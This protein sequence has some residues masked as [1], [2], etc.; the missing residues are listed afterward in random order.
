MKDNDSLAQNGKTKLQLVAEMKDGKFN[1]INYR[2]TRDERSPQYYRISTGAPFSVGG[3]NMPINTI[4]ALEVMSTFSPQEWYVINL[5]KNVG[6]VHYDSET[7][8]SYS[9]NIVSLKGID[10]DKRKFSIG[11]K[12]LHDK[13][14]VKRIKR[15]EYIINPL[16]IMP[17]YF[18]KEYKLW[19]EIE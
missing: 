14:L 16:F 19:K 12:R 3:T 17:T 5:L 2:F 8:R 1:G 6:L 7:K 9:S 11:Y 15:Q 18:E 13:D 10:Y 4:D